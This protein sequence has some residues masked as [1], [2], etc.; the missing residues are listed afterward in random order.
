MRAAEDWARGQDAL[1]LVLTVWQGNELA[2]AFYGALGYA[3][4]SQVLGRDL[5]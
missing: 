1:Q 2:E 4:V 5:E 3:R